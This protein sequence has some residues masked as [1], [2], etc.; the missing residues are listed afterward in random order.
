[1]EKIFYKKTAKDFD[2][3]P[4]SRSWIKKT[5]LSFKLHIK[6][7]WQRKTRGF[8]DR[9]LWSLDY[10]IAKFALPRLIAFKE[11]KY[12]HPSR[13]EEQEWDVILSDIIRGFKYLIEDEYVGD[14]FK[15]DS[16]D[17]GI[18]LFGKFFSDLWD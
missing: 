6:W 9:E 1:M 14:K 16:I 7:W 11:I 2:I 13:I 18:K 4:K 5:L 3:G 10:T 8:D 12:S 15:E 17:S